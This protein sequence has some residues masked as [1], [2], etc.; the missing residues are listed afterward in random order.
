MT[1]MPTP[2]RDLGRLT[3]LFATLTPAAWRQAVRMTVAAVS[4]YLGTAW[5]GLPEGYWAVITCLVIVQGSLGSTLSAGI[6]RVHGTVIGALLGLGGALIHVWLALPTAWA[7]GLLVLP[8]S[9]LAAHNLRYRLAPVTAALVLL[10]I[11]PGDGLFAIAL[12][13]IA[14][15]LLGAVIGIA[16]ALLVLPD[17][18]GTEVRVHGASA[19]KILGELVRRQVTDAGGVDELGARLQEYIAGVEAAG[20]DVVQERYY[21]LSGEPASGPLL[22]I[23]RRLRTD[24]GMIGRTAREQTCTVEER[25]A[26]AGPIASWFDAASRALFEAN[27]APNL[28]AVE[29]AG[30]TL[31]PGTPLTLV[32]T[33]ICRDLRDLADRITERSHPSTPTDYGGVAKR[34]RWLWRALPRR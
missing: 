20:E 18:G 31:R 29:L 23:L 24:V 4:A 2:V 11:Q 26:F 27:V 28:A 5:F 25:T 10:A 30:T 7:L 22:R 13:R 16:A 15:I 32:H 14:E 3:W 33:I 6:S 8:L 34:S 1:P 9:L 12:Y 21:H 17:R 19:L